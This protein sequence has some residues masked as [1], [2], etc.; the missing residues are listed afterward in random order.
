M[1]KIAQL[2]AL[3]LLTTGTIGAGCNGPLSQETRRQHAG[4]NSP[5]ISSTIAGLRKEH[6]QIHFGI[7][8]VDY[9]ERHRR[10]QALLSEWIAI[11]TSSNELVYL[12][13][14]PTEPAS[15][16]TPNANRLGY[17]IDSGFVG[18]VWNFYIK[19]DKVVRIETEGFD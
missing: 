10:M 19:N 14:P 13:G 6:G 9:Q 3:L 7:S 1:P 11:G 2:I 16:R 18:A 5:A 8:P 15:R 17:R 12:L 4:T